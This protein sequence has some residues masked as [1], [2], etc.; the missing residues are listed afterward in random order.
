VRND[1]TVL[2]YSSGLDN[3]QARFFLEETAE[4]YRIKEIIGIYRVN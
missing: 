1:G 4:G 2:N 3:G